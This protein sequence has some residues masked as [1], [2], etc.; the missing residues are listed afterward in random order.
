MAAGLP[1]IIITAL[2]LIIL[3]VWMFGG[4]GNNKGRLV[5]GSAI[6]T[7]LAAC[8]YVLLVNSAVTR[9]GGI[10]MGLGFFIAIAVFFLP[11]VWKWYVERREN[12]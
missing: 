2:A 4:P 9:V 6:I 7:S 5:L 8:W 11:P 3:V 12:T 1:L 10:A